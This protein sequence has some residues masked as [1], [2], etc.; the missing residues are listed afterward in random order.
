MAAEAIFDDLIN[1]LA[2]VNSQMNILRTS[3][4]STMFTQGDTK[5][6]ATSYGPY[7]SSIIPDAPQDKGLLLINYRPT[8]GV[9]TTKE[10]LNEAFIKKTLEMTFRSDLYPKS[11]VSVIIKE[12]GNFGGITSC[13]LNAAFLSL[14]DADIITSFPVAAITS[15]VDKNDKFIIEPNHIEMKNVKTLFNFSYH[16]Q[17]TLIASHTEGVFIREQYMGA[18]QVCRKAS[19]RIFDHYDQIANT[20]KY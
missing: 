18:I 10:L 6:F 19:Q 17:G 4:G 3:S 20:V 9:S 2:P 15:I 1:N 12:M 7:P 5:M 16:F 13:A 11:V 8:V 14:F